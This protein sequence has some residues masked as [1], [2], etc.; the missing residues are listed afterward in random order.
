MVVENRH[1]QAPHAPKQF[2]AQV[3]RQTLRHAN[4]HQSL[5]DAEDAGC[6]AIAL[7]YGVLGLGRAVFALG[8]ACPCAASAKEDEHCEENARDRRHDAHGRETRNSID[9]GRHMRRKR[10]FRLI[11]RLLQQDLID[12]DL[13]EPRDVQTRDQGNETQ[14]DLAQKQTARGGDEL[15]RSPQDPRHFRVGDPGMGVKAVVEVRTRLIRRGD[16]AHSGNSD[17]SISTSALT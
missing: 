4:V 5:D 8:K 9:K 17:T 11:E 16:I 15:Q 2:D 13:R 14:A 10:Y 3:V 1:R 12:D 7:A 6:P